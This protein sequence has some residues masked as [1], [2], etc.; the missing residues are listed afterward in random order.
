M[1]GI[2]ATASIAKSAANNISFFN[3][4]PPYER[5]FNDIVYSFIHILYC[6][7]LKYSFF[8]LFLK[9]LNILGSEGEAEISHRISLEPPYVVTSIRSRHEPPEGIGAAEDRRSTKRRRARAHGPA[10]SLAVPPALYRR[11]VNPPGVRLLD[12]LADKEAAAGHQQGAGAE[13]EQ[14]GSA[15]SASLRQLLLLFFLSL[16]LLLLRLGRRSRGS[17]RR[18]SRGSLRRRSRGRRGSRSGLAGGRCGLVDFLHALGRIAG[19]A[20]DAG[21]ALLELEVVR[22]GVGR[23]HVRHTLAVAALA[24]TLNGRTLVSVTAATGNL[25]RLV[26]LAALAF[27]LVL[28]LD[29]RQ[30]G[31]RGY[32]HHR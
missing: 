26:N 20:R 12:D 13:R 3:F 23:D 11:P 8:L 16:G 29:L 14:R 1:A 27:L 31:R 4:T 2:A 15:T 25:N 17:L 9:K 28:L 10:S 7:Y 24:D 30:S 19:A 18:R 32:Q 22:L 21:A 6:Q 5:A